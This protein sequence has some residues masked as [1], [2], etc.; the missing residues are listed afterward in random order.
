MKVLFDI[1]ERR[2]GQVLSNICW[3]NNSGSPLIT[4]MTNEHIRNTR[5]W[6]WRQCQAYKALGYDIPKNGDYDYNQWL[7]IL[8]H[9]EIRRERIEIEKTNK[10]MLQMEI[11]TLSDAQRRTRAK[12]LLETPTAENIREYDLLMGTN[13]ASAL[14]KKQ[15]TD[16]DE[17]DWV[18]ANA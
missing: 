4:E 12:K 10:V 14:S 13:F 3:K 17:D 7:I 1:D 5:A 2:I 16:E 18:K 11:K 8:K 15:Q 9:E 6:L